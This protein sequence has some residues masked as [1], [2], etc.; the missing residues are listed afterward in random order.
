M[1]FAV[2]VPVVPMA[3]AG[4]APSVRSRRRSEHRAAAPGS[5]GKRIH[6]HSNDLCAGRRGR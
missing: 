6:F 2:Y 5:F 1:V 4:S 3:S